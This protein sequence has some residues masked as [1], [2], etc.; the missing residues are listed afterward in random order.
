MSL[1]I[2]DAGARQLGAIEIQ[3]CCQSPIQ[4]TGEAPTQWA[5]STFGFLVSGSNMKVNK[6]CS[7]HM[8]KICNFILEQNF[9]QHVMQHR[10]AAG[11]A[12]LYAYFTRAVD[13]FD[14]ANSDMIIY[15]NI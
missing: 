8:S 12:A 6:L 5:A 11:T 14:A 4:L 10:T 1:V 2:T 15:H 13:H 3:L 9:L 7:C